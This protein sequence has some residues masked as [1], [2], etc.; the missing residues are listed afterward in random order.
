MLDHADHL[1]DLLGGD[2]VGIGDDYI[3]YAI[4]QTKQEPAEQGVTWTDAD[5]EYP[6]GVST[7]S[8]LGNLL[9]RLESRGHSPVR[10]SKVAGDLA[11]RRRE[12]PA[13]LGSGRTGG[14]AMTTPG[15]FELREASVLDESGGFTGPLNIV[16]WGGRVDA[17][18]ANAAASGAPEH[19]FSGLWVLPG[20]IDCHEH[21]AM[22][23]L[24][25]M[26]FLR[27]PI[28]YWAIEATANARRLLEAGVTLVR[29]PGGPTRAF[30]T[31]LPPAT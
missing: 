8:E 11:S 6:E 12:L 29:D 4:E 14:K 19:D 21:V 28:T 13:G 10:I 2:S 31:R 5:F 30:A 3:D 26:A 15:D 24:D 1:L 22:S 9:P 23:S 27:T 18:E 25:G 7:F 17:V 16:V 20:I